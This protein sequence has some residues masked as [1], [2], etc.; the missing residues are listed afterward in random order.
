[1]ANAMR[2]SWGGEDNQLWEMYGGRVLLTIG[3]LEVWDNGF[4]YYIAPTMD[5]GRLV[6]DSLKIDR[7]DSSGETVGPPVST[8]AIRGAN[9]NKWLESTIESFVAERVPGTDD[10]TKRHTWPPEDFAANGPTDE[11]LDHMAQMYA[12]LM[13]QGKRPSGVFLEMYGIPRPTTTKWIA[14]A[15]KRKIL[16]DDHRRIK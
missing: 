14:A 3:P 15:R 8:A 6:C 7:L 4:R 16:V 1:M 10:Y 5:G 13:V 9:V 11:A 2:I 12:W